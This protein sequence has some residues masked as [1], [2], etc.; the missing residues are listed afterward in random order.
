MVFVSLAIG[1]SLLGAFGAGVYAGHRAVS[2]PQF[3]VVSGE[4]AVTLLA[5]QIRQRDGMTYAEWQARRLERVGHV[6]VTGYIP[7]HVPCQPHGEWTVQAKVTPFAAPDQ[8]TFIYTRT[9]LG[10]V[11]S[12]GRVLDLPQE[13]AWV[14]TGEAC[15][16]LPTLSRSPSMGGPTWLDDFRSG[17]AP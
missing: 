7:I 6:T 1:L 17:A 13:P 10:V 2:S 8:R 9:E 12:D 11:S 4:Q 15:A 5:G 16:A 14:R 3:Q